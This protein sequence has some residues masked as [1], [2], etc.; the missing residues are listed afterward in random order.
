MRSPSRNERMAVLGS[1]VDS[2]F[3][4]FDIARIYGFGQ[5]EAELGKFLHT[6]ERDA[7]TVA[8]KF[9]IDTVGAA[10]RL[11]GGAGAGAAPKSAGATCD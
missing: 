6:V 7:V 1:A 5:A 9:G 8:T 2:G 11:A 10:R 4:H 3:T